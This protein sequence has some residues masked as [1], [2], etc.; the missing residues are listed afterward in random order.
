MLACAAV[1]TNVTIRLPEDLADEAK[2][3]A[4]S[5]YRSLSNLIRL[6]LIQYLDRPAVPAA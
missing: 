1:D 3:R 6:A 4:E 5:E 2:A